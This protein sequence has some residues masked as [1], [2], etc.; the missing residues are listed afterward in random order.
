MV[1]PAISCFPPRGYF[2]S[3]GVCAA[4]S[5]HVSTSTACP[6]VHLFRPSEFSKIVALCLCGMKFLKTVFCFNRSDRVSL[7]CP[8][9]SPGQIPE[10]QLLLPWNS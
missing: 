9:S 10:K 5:S 8:Q 2:L 6:I 1:V 7:T 3:R 4:T